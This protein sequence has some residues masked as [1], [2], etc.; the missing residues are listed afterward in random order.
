MDDMKI[1]VDDMP[2]PRDWYNFLDR[3]I[4]WLGVVSMAISVLFLFAYNWDLFGRY[5]KFGLIEMLILMTIVAYTLVDT[6]TL[7][8][9]ALLLVSSILLGV[10]LAFFGQTYQTGADPW[11]LFFNWALLM[12][13]WVM[14]GRFSALWIVWVILIN[15]SLLLY[16]NVYDGLFS[17]I[18]VS[19]FHYYWIVFIFNTAVWAFWEM[20]S[21]KFIWL[22]D[23]WSIRFLA[24][25]SGF[26]ITA[27]MFDTIF[28]SF[29]IWI[30]SIW[31]VWIISVYYIYLYRI[32]NLFILAVLSLSLGSI[33]IAMFGRQIFDSSDFGDYLYMSIVV[34]SVGTLL[35]YWL[36]RLHRRISYE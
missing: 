16:V 12:L 1:S 3:L 8:A 2:S 17:F 20:L 26:S 5:A 24:L 30:V 18:F 4:L 33:T 19:K 9:K 21:S 31:A 22:D 14:L 6:E 36:Q 32:P 28:G 35:G 13:P 23:G 29:D 34:V 15:L 25:A 11:Q 27:L 7:I 10:L